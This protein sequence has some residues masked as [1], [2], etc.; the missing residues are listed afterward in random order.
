MGYR[1]DVVI[2]VSHRVKE[3]ILDEISKHNDEFMVDMLNNPDIQNEHGILIRFTAVK[4][5]ADFTPVIGIIE[6][7]MEENEEESRFVRVGEE[8]CDSEEWGEFDNV[9]SFY[10]IQMIHIEKPAK[11]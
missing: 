7:I 4:W 2:S 11:A 10:P 9:R 8:Y 1:S 6:S 3:L 5:H